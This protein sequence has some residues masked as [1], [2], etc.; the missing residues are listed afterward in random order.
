MTMNFDQ[1]TQRYRELSH[2]SRHTNRAH[3]ATRDGY[4]HNAIELFREF[5]HGLNQFLFDSIELGFKAILNCAVTCLH[6][7]SA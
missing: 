2:S 4:R 1:G 5:K 6:A 7:T 3:H